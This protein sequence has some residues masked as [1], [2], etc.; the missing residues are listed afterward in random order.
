[1]ERSFQIADDWYVVPTHLPVPS[2]GLLPMNTMVIRSREPVLVD[3]NCPVFRDEYLEAVFSLVEPRDVRWIFLSH[4]DRDHSG[5]LAVVLERCPNAR[6][7]TSFVGV[8]R[9]SEEWSV[10]LERVHFLNPDE[11]IDVGDRTLQA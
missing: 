3:T 8:G 11:T 2:V 5:N 6:V 4:D 9:L 7:I 10:P 1:M